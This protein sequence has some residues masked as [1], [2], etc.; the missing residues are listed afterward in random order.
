M[1][2]RVALCVYL[3][4]CLVSVVGCPRQPV[5][6]LSGFDPDLVGTYEGSNSL[7]PANT[8][9]AQF[10]ATQFTLT[11]ENPDL[12]LLVI[13]GGIYAVDTS[14]T[15]HRIDFG[16]TRC[17]AVNLINRVFCRQVMG[18]TLKGLYELDGNGLRFVYAPMTYP[19]PPQIDMVGYFVFEGERVEDEV[20]RA[21]ELDDKAA[22]EEDV[23]ILE[24]ML[25]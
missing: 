7:M 9:V 13:L 4:V 18:Q 20:L 14:S 3:V 10:T 15:P 22:D 19:R 11:E 25:P 21:I 24:G 5:L 17:V 8:N 1:I 16:I 2:A 12:G 23:G 6:T